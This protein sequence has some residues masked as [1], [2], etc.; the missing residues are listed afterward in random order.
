MS[1]AWWC[2]EERKYEFRQERLRHE[3][4]LSE[5]GSGTSSQLGKGYPR[6]IGST[7]KNLPLCVCLTFFR[8][9]SQD[10]FSERFSLSSLASADT[11]RHR[12]NWFPLVL[13][14]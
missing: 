6:A 13:V 1:R 9:R 4:G 8:H 12:H 11:V 10:S 5:E 3:T 2:E 7:A 14:T